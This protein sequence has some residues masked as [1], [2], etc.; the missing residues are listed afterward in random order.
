[1]RRIAPAL[2]LFTACSTAAYGDTESSAAGSTGTSAATAATAATSATDGDGASTG[3][4]TTGGTG[5]GTTVVETGGETGGAG[6]DYG[7]AG[8]NPPGNQTFTLELQGR[9]LLVEVWYPA[10]PA[11][12]AAAEAG[13]SIV[14]FVPPGPDRDA[15]TGLLGM[16]GQPGMVGVT[17]Q[18][19]SARDA[20]PADMSQRPLVVFSHCHSCTRFSVFTIA[21]HLASRGFIVAAPD[22][23]GNTL[24]DE[25]KGMSA[26]IGEEF[27]KVRVADMS[28][29][30]DALLDPNDQAVPA[31]IRGAIDPAKIGAMG[32]SY[33]SATAGRL[34][35]DD[36]RIVAAM[37]IF[38][39]VENPFFPGTKIADIAEPT[40][41]ALAVE[42]NSILQIGNDLIGANFK[43]AATPTRLLTIKD[44][45]HWGVT[46]ICGLVS[47]FDPGCGPGKRM[48]DGTD[49]T[50]LEPAI[51]RAAV[52]AYAAAFFDLHLRG[53]QS[54][55]DYL[56]VA[57]PAAFVE[58]MSR[59]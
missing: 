19:H 9:S 44:A 20:A 11:A 5:G 51:V 46:D 8:A 28:G 13:E 21:E 1:M 17:T 14:E 41:F 56:D 30:V 7:Q 26:D 53:N 50:Y 37:P 33:G 23:A 40:L 36:D 45:G 43:M 39:P 12:Q 24:F 55:A 16:L 29:V 22:H 10:D 38:A 59:P 49:F 52:G 35:Q 54:A 4:P 15:L 6:E 27:L 42:D 57:Q 18:T 32:H 3:V 47:G 25:L 48:T 2:L 31:A 34:A 58:V